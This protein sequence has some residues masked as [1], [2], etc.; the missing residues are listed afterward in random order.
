MPGFRL[1][2]EVPFF[3]GISSLKELEKLLE[4]AELQFL[5]Y[6]HEILPS[7]D[8]TSMASLQ[9]FEHVT[10][11]LH[12]NYYRQTPNILRSTIKFCV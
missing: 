8:I 2:F 10:A 3:D 6:G 7:I 5:R 1:L 9:S 12:S 11:P 4:D